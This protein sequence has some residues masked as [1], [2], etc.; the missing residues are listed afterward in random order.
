MT[1]SHHDVKFVTLHLTV[2]TLLYLRKCLLHSAGVV[3][4]DDGDNM[5]SQAPHISTY[6][7]ELLV[8]YPDAKGPVRRY[9]AMLRQLLTSTTSEW[10][11][12]HLQRNL[13]TLS[14]SSFSVSIVSDSSS[15]P[16]PV[17]GAFTAHNLLTLS[18]SLFSVSIVSDSCSPPPPVSGAVFVYSV[19]C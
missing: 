4:E 10:R 1:F 7:N 15:H 5:K 11:R 19:I 3:A 6:V 8:K 18:G 17:S 9:V 13:L 14:G 2:Q 12:F 16:P